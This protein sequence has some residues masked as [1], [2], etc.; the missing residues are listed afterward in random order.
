LDDSL[1]EIIYQMKNLG[2]I[3]EDID[4]R[5]D[6]SPFTRKKIVEALNTIF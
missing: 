3:L 6:K 5:F 2:N 1:R 4:K